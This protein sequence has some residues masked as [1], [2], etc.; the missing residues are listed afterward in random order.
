MVLQ[1]GYSHYYF[2]TYQIKGSAAA[3]VRFALLLFLLLA[4]DNNYSVFI[5]F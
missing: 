3:V 4:F 1:L 5:K 2:I